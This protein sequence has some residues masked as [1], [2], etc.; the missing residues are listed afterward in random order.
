MKNLKTKG[1]SF[2]QAK[3]K[4]IIAIAIIA[5]IG[6]SFNACIINTG[7]D[8]GGSTTPNTSL[9]GTWKESGTIINING[10]IG[11]F[12]QLD[13]NWP[14]FWLDAV[15]KGYVKVGDQYLKSLN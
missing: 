6:F 15:R 12:M 7:D 2:A 4:A 9:N 11:T 1:V 8:S 3:L 13:S 5:I 14:D 10:S